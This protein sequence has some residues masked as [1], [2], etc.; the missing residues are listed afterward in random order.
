MVKYLVLEII[1]DFHWKFP[2]YVKKECKF[3][4]TLSS[5]SIYTKLSCTHLIFLSLHRTKNN[6]FFCS[7][8]AASLLLEV[9]SQDWKHNNEKQSHKRQTSL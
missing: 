6:S 2:V 1:F 9:S 7:F 4:L 8:F 5:L 3:L